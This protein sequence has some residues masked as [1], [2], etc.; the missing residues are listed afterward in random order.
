MIQI[1][2]NT[3]KSVSELLDGVTRY[4]STPELIIK[5][6]DDVKF[7]VIEKVK[8][9]CV[10]K[11]YKINDID[12]VRVEFENGWALVRA[13]NTGPNITVRFEGVTKEDMESIQNEF[14]KLI[15]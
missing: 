9:Y 15:D 1:L 11:G 7:K 5:S 2:S 6:S 12:G 4:Y 14:M 8:K 10:E 3:N 13:S